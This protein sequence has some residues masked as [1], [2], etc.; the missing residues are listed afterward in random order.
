[1]L[2]ENKKRLKYFLE[3]GNSYKYLKGKRKQL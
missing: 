1:M 3:K 2:R